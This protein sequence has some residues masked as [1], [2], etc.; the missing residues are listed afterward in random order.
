M[1]VNQDAV[2]I[3]FVK[4]SSDEEISFLSSKL[5]ERLQDD[6]ADVLDYVGRNGSKHHNIDNLFRSA[7]NCWEIYDLCDALQKVVCSEFEKRK[8]NIRTR[9]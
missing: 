5:V 7:S 9:N 4:N 8:I 1:K 6:L 3:E 2:L